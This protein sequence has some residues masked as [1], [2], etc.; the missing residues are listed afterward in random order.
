MPSGVGATT[1]VNDPRAQGVVFAPDPA[2]FFELTEKNEYTAFSVDVPGSGASATRQLPQSGILGHVR[3]I[4]DGVITAT[5][6][7]GAVTTSSR[8]PY[9]FL[10]QLTISANAQNDLVSARGTDLHVMRA[11]RHPG[12]IPNDGVDLVPGGIGAGQTLAGGANPLV[13]TWDVPIA[14]D[15]TSLIGALYAQSPSTALQIALRQAVTG[16]LLVTSGTATVNSITGTF[17]VQVTSFDIPISSGEQPGL[18]VPDLSRLH[19]INGHEVPFSNTGDVRAPLIRTNGQLDRLIFAATIRDPAG[20]T[21][22]QFMSA[23]ADADQIAAVRLEYGAANRPLSYDPAHFLAAKNL[24]D[25]ADELPLEHYVL[26]FL[27]EN[28][29]RD[30]ILM[31][32]VTDL[33]LVVEVDAGVA[34]AAGSAVRLVQ[35]TLFK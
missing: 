24:Q 3:I 27:A 4:F 13:L 8:W 6:G 25:Y 7:T 29:P 21:A 23:N 9:G 11:I 33:V 10:D 34:L 30:V 31:A 32:G 26:D 14:I 18:I 16:D 28:A 20:Q 1:L 35:E 22:D 19:G 5:L 2:A 12:F 17:F 15:D